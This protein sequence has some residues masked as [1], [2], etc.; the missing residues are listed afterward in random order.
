MPP[1][2]FELSISVLEGAKTVHASDRAAT[3]IGEVEKLLGRKSSGS[4]LEI[5]NT[6]VGIR[7]ADRWH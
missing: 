3:A 1:V 7:R 5:Y 4:C 6:V 2:G